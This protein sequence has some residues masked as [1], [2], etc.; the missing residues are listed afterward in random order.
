MTALHNTTIST[1]QEA[2]AVGSYRNVKGQQFSSQ[3]CKKKN[4]TDRF[5]PYVDDATFIHKQILS[6]DLFPPHSFSEVN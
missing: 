5:S 1:L 4:P 3:I 2:N 6:P